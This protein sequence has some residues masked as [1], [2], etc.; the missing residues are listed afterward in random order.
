MV[1]DGHLHRTTGVQ[2]LLG[3]PCPGVAPGSARSGG[4]HDL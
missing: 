3:F 1:A 4:Q 2:Q